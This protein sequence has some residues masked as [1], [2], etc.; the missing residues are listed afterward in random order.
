MIE[1]I[2]IISLVVCFISYVGV[3]AAHQ[4]LDALDK[5]LNVDST[6]LPVSDDK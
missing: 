1:L 2:M 3:C 5:Y 4:R 6:S